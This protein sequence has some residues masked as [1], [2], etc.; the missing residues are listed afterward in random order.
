MAEGS[1]GRADYF[2]SRA[3]EDAEFAAWLGRLIAAQG[4]TYILQDKHF[5]HQNSMG[6]MDGA[7]ES[8]AHV[9]G[10]LSQAY[11]ESD[12]CLAEAA[13]ALKGDPL[14]RQQRLILLR[15][16]PCAPGGVLANIPYTSL[17]DERRDSDAR[18]LTLS[19]STARPS[20]ACRPRPPAR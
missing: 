13:A 5:G 10:L 8:G 9:V 16:E 6:T 3:G 2:I 4:K 1:A 20:T 12:Y 19:A 7:L 11:L 18:P 15:L 14:N 17:L